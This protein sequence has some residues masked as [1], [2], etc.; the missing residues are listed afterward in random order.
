[1]GTFS[2]LLSNVQAQLKKNDPKA[3]LDVIF[4][5]ERSR[6][7]GYNP[8]QQETTD[9]LLLLQQALHEDKKYN[10]NRQRAL[11]NIM[12]YNVNPGAAHFTG[13]SPSKFAFQLAL[14]VRE[15]NLISQ[16]DLGLCGANAAVIHFAKTNPIG[17]VDLGIQLMKTGKGMFGQSKVEPNDTLKS[18]VTKLRLEEADYVV[19]ASVRGSAGF[20]DWAFGN[21]KEGIAEGMTEDDVIKLL[22]QAGYTE[23]EDHAASFK[24]F[25]SWDENL[26]LAAQRVSLGRLVIV[27]IHGDLVRTMKSDKK[28]QVDSL[29]STNE[30]EERAKAEAARKPGSGK[31][32]PPV[33][34][35]LT[36][37][38]HWVLVS[39]LVVSGEEVTIKLYS[40]GESLNRTMPRKNFLS[41]YGGFV[42]ARLG[43]E[44]VPQGIM[45]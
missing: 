12:T 9:F 29:P 3:A 44:S 19:L 1:M 2:N 20:M 13:V 5:L 38:N 25:S 43:G 8:S 17:Y 37:T 10:P 41:C 39:K 45:K 6:L 7:R 28:K 16:G 18:G 35:V 34:S 14:R 32:D 31:V 30:P 21:S 36:P 22:K 42:C 40:W 26:A 24:L 15:P 4:G 11:V 27:G 23:V 33:K